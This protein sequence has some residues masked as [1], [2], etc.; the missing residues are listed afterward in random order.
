MASLTLQLHP[1][2][3]KQMGTWMHLLVSFD[4]LITVSLGLKL[5]WMLGQ[6]VSSHCMYIFHLIVKIS[7]S[8]YVVTFVCHNV[9]LQINQIHEY[10]EKMLFKY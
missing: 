6:L 1:Q 5:C 2:D 4:R 8:V 7:V 9:L 10:I 3:I